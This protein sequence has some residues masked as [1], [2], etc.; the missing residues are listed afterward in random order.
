MGV[1]YK[2][3][4]SSSILKFLTTLSLSIAGTGKHET[5]FSIVSTGR[6]ERRKQVL[7]VVRIR[8]CSAAAD[9][10]ADELKELIAF[11]KHSVRE[12]GRYECVEKAGEVRLGSQDVVG[13]GTEYRRSPYPARKTGKS[14]GGYYQ[15]ASDC[16]DRIFCAGHESGY[17]HGRALAER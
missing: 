5:T 10:R 13:P 16:S 1:G 11:R 17:A 3:R 2:R 8:R 12:S 6:L 15:Y 4:Y 7:A 9:D 14:P